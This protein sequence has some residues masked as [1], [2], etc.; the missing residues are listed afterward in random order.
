MK[1]SFIKVYDRSA[2]NK[3]IIIVFICTVFLLF[4]CTYTHAGIIVSAEESEKEV[5]HTIIFTDEKENEV[6]EL[7]GISTLKVKY[8]VKNV[9]NATFFL[10]KY[11]AK[12][13]LIDTDAASITETTTDGL[14]TMNVT[15]AAIVTLL[16]WYDKTLKPL[17][18]PYTMGYTLQNASIASVKDNKA[19]M[20]TFI[21]DDG[22]WDSVNYYH[23][24][25]ESLGL[26]GT[27]ALIPGDIDEG[28]DNRGTWKEWREFFSDNIFSVANHTMNHSL[29]NY[30]NKGKLTEE[31]LEEQINGGKKRILEMLPGQKV[32]G[33]VLPGNKKDD[34]GSVIKKAK[35]QHA[36]VRLTEGYNVLPVADEEELYAIHY[37]S[38]R[39]AHTSDNM[40]AW[41]DT[42]IS[43][44]RW[45]VEMWHDVRADGEETT[46]NFTPEKRHATAHFQYIANKQADLWVANWDDG[47]A[48]VKERLH[49]KILCLS[50]TENEIQIIVKDDLD[51]ALFDV[52]L[53]LNIEMPVGWENVQVVQNEQRIAT[54]VNGGIL[55]INVVP[56]SGIVTIKKAK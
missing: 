10:A 37:K 22:F 6:D 12:G 9:N 40:N 2:E 55:S 11:D 38:I 18:E 51:D 48:Y 30:M 26:T 28:K 31:I 41:I 32:L 8:D 7:N 17:F 19:A 43:K 34:A 39:T 45:L 13:M 25:F 36:G 16:S 20:Y 42:A 3:K 46:S 4:L 47:I 49:A 1:S 53:T 33:L 21:T 56:D 27:V 35:E 15:D 14:L 24:L 5:L 44:K 50:Q 52:A 54:R 29:A 23:D